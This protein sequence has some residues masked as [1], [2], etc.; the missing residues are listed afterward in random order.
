[1][2]KLSD[3]PRTDAQMQLDSKRYNGHS[4]DYVSLKIFTEQLEQELNELKAIHKTAITDCQQYTPERW[5]EI[6]DVQEPAAVWLD[7][8]QMTELMKDKERL[9]WVL[10]HAGQYWLS[11]REDINK[12]M[13]GR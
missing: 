9:D 1:M 2:K 6:C 3:T 12:E 13:E 5:K 8:K 7:G 10:S 4:K 11:L